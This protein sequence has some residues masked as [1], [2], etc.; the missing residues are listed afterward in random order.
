MISSTSLSPS[1]AGGHRLVRYY[2]GEDAVSGEK[3]LLKRAELLPEGVLPPAVLKEIYYLKSLRSPHV[4]PLLDVVLTPS[5]IYLVLSYTGPTLLELLSTSPNPSDHRVVTSIAHSLLE[6]LEWIH[7]KSVVHLGLEPECVTVGKDGE[8]RLDGFGISQMGA[9]SGRGRSNDFHFSAYSAPELLTPTLPS[10]PS[11]DMWSFGLLLLTLLTHKLLP[12][13]T[14]KST[15][16]TFISQY[17]PDGE[18]SCPEGLFRERLQITNNSA[19][20]LLQKL[21][22]LDPTQRLTATEAKSHPFFSSYTP[23]PETEE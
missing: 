4:Q 19:I 21:L 17:I 8:V 1:S 22:I 9:G 16:K 20:D 3:I 15:F 18:N 11:S 14:T 7:S 6:R 2:I 13:I 23:S 12:L 5:H 10:S